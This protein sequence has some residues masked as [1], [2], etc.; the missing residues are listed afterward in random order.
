M[1]QTQIISTKYRYLIKITWPQHKQNNL[2]TS[3][4]H[5]KNNSFKFKHKTITPI[6]AI[7][8]KIIFMK[9]YPL[10]DRGTPRYATIYIPTATSLRQ[11][12]VEE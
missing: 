1:S 6:K 12:L 5:Q 4:Y 10:K 9:R 3:Q 7:N 2:K 11:G 8:N